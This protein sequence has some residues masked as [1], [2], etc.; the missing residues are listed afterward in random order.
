MSSIFQAAE[1][2]FGVNEPPVLVLTVR[3]VNGALTCE[4]EENGV[5]SELGLLQELS[6][7]VSIDKDY[8]VITTKRAPHPPL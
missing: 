4:L 3:S 5:L 6:V 2:P 8:P 1:T 7:T